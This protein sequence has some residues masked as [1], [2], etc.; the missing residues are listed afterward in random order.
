MRTT[1][2]G[3][4]GAMGWLSVVVVLAGCPRPGASDESDAAVSDEGSSGEGGQ[5][6]S[7]ATSGGG[8]SGGAGGGAGGEG[9]AGGAGAGGA[10]GTDQDGGAA[11]SADQDGGASSGPACNQAC[12]AYQHCELVEVACIQAPCPPQPECVD[13][14]FCGGIAAFTCPG[15]GVC[16][17]DPRDDCDPENGGADC[18]GVCVCSGPGGCA[19]GET[20]DVAKCGCVEHLA[21]GGV[22]CGD[23]TCE[24]GQVCCDALC[25]VCA[26]PNALCTQGC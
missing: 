16:E 5:G 20:W 8:A 2:R 19:P 22:K 12:E 23:N 21:D 17:D 7:G 14:P 6:G 11:G 25:G 9:G 13:N 26:A 3:V 24:V 15:A 4:S 10:G 1:I 18:G